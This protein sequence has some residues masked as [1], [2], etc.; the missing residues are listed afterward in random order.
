MDEDDVTERE[1]GQL[2]YGFLRYPSQ[3]IGTG[4]YL[5]LGRNKPSSMKMKNA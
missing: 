1:F 2:L 4:R 5:V 3:Y